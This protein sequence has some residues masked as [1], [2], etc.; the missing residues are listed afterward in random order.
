MSSKP[1][2]LHPG[3]GV[4]RCPAV[5]SL[6][7]EG[8]LKHED[9]QTAAVQDLV[10][11]LSGQPRDLAPFEAGSLGNV[12]GFF[13]IFNHGVPQQAIGERRGIGA[14]IRGLF[15][16]GRNAVDGTAVQLGKST[17]RRFNLRFLGSDGDHP[18]TVDFFSDDERGEF[19]REHFVSVMT[20]VSDGATLTIEGIARMILMANA[21]DSKA[22]ALD[23]AKSSGEWALMVCALR[24]DASTTD[25]SIADLERMFSRA[26]STQLLKGTQ[27]ATALEW[28]KVTAQI[29]TAIAR[30]KVS[31][32]T[33]LHSAFKQF[34]AGGQ[35]LCPCATCN[36]EVWRTLS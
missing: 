23:L 34:N 22:S 16:R 1:I 2:E 31:A 8:K 21:R 13:A 12:G 35:Q 11:T 26:D 18:G 30:E 28:I 32:I 20:A 24:A 5:R 27:R 3:E 4:I 9:L 7:K 6:I 14:R 19:Q 17:T 25:I 36:P 29:A 10:R 33:E 15:Q